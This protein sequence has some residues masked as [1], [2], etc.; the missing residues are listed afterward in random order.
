MRHALAV[1]LASLFVASANAGPKEDAF[2]VVER[3][4]KAYD[5]S[6]PV[7]ITKLFAPGAI[8]LGTLMQKP[9]HD[10]GDIIKYFQS[11]AAAN[12]PK[13]VE[14][15]NYETPQL[16]DTAFLF[17][18]QNIFFHTRDG[19]FVET[20]ARFSILVSKTSEGWLISHFHSSRRPP[21]P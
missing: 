15:E 7:A 11:S 18:G 2:G 13:K 3:F 21:V 8:F 9:S 5:A 17:S 4:K 10:A 16:S 6:D 14:I 20:P 1:L 12:L 19:K